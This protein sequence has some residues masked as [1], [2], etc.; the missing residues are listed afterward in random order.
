MIIGRE[1]SDLKTNV[2][3]SL[4][5]GLREKDMDYDRKNYRDQDFR[6][7]EIAV[8]REYRDDI[9]RDLREENRKDFR[10]DDYK[11]L[12]DYT[13]RDHYLVNP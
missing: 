13:L 1:I 10:E 8:R 6:A 2:G 3:Y 7:S 4:N 9:R 5:K 12:R 11:D